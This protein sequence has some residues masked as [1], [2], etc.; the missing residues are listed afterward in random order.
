MPDWTTRAAERICKYAQRHNHPRAY[1]STETAAA[2]CLLASRIF[3][4]KHPRQYIWRQIEAFLVERN[5]L[6]AIKV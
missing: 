3:R 1:F 2:I 4:A 5:F 6:R